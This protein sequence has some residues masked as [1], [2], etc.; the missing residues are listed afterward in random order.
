MTIR[1]SFTYH[2]NYFIYCNMCCFERM[3]SLLIAVNHS[4]VKE[5]LQ[6]IWEGLHAEAMKCYRVPE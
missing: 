2:L 5:G 6:S 3:T 4:G 1:I